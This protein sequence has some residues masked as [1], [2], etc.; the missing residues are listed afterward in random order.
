[1]KRGGS[2]G[3]AL[4]TKDATPNAVLDF[5]LEGL[6]VSPA[7]PY[8]VRLLTQGQR[9]QWLA[10][11]LEV[12]VREDLFVTVPRWTAGQHRAL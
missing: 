11:S 12:P 7:P 1:M 6:E 2:P 9:G 3:G 10:A 8:G 4:D 5:R